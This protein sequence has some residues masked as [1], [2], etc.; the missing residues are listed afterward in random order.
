[1]TGKVFLQI[2]CTPHYCI[3]I[4]VLCDENEL[5]M[6]SFNGPNSVHCHPHLI[7]E[8]LP[9][10]GVRIIRTNHPEPMKQ[11][12]ELP[13]QVKGGCMLLHGR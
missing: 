7:R 5:D 3:E 9:N 8:V 10:H 13:E 12:S 6:P 4:S 2:R 1:M 11:K